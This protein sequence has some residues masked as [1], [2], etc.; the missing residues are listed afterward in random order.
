VGLGAHRR[1]SPDWW[2]YLLQAPASGRRSRSK[3]KGGAAASRG[4]Y[5]NGDGEE[6]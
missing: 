1:D 2:L 4:T 3:S 5:R 6:G